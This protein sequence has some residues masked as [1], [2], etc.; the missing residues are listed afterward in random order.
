MY[1]GALTSELQVKADVTDGHSS[2]GTNAGSNGVLDKTELSFRLNKAR[3]MEL[4]VPSGL[5]EKLELQVNHQRLNLLLPCFIF[6]NQQ[7]HAAAA[8]LHCAWPAQHVCVINA[9]ECRGVTCVCMCL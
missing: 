8:C 9:R 4:L 3:L 1:V 6:T 5:L 7:Y 2:S